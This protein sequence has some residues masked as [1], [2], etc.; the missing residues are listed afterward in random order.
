MAQKPA[1]PQAVV[2]VCESCEGH[3]SANY[4]REHE[5][6][7]GHCQGTSWT[8]NVAFVE[9][10]III[11][12]TILGIILRWITGIGGHPVSKSHRVEMTFSGVT[13]ADALKVCE[14]PFREQYRVLE[15]IKYR[16]ELDAEEQREKMIDR[17]GQNCST[18]GALFVPSD[19]R[20][21]TQ[22][23][24]CSKVCFAQAF[25]SFTQDS[26]DESGRPN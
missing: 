5:G 1:L 3:Y 17:G 22:A 7:C 14:I 16:Q 20:P 24:C 21:W 25:D 13:A 9:Q 15:Y 10:E 4:I 23:G 26:K 19:N 8:L 11:S 2:F 6:S 18:C 12:A